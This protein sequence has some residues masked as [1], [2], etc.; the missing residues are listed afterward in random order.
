MDVGLIV[1]I[2]LAMAFALT[3]GFRLFAVSSGIGA[4]WV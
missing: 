2:G 4:G 3:N 1:A